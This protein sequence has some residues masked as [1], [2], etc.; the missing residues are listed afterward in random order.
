MD[1]ARLVEVKHIGATDN[2][3][4][5]PTSKCDD[6]VRSMIQEEVAE[7]FSRYAAVIN[8][9]QSPAVALEVVINESRA[10]PFFES[11]LRRYEIPGEVLVRP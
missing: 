8:D 3:P 5:V 1:S 10:A 6:Y 11:L 9:P 7:E 2:S 4:F